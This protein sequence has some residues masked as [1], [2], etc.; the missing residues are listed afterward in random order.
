MANCNLCGASLYDPLNLE[1]VT[2]TTC[3]CTTPLIS[4][5][6]ANTG[7]CVESVTING[8]LQTGAVNFTITPYSTATALAAISAV[9]PILYNSGTGVISHY[10]SLVTGSP[11]TYG[12]ATFVPQ[13]TVDDKGHITAVSQVA[14]TTTALTTNLTNLD[15]GTT[16]SGTGYLVRTGTNTWVLRSLTTASSSRITITN[17]A[18]TAAATIFDLAS[19]VV[20]TGSG[21]YGSL[22]TYPIITVDTYGRVTGITTQTFP[23]AVIP[24]HSHHLGELSNVDST[25]G[26]AGVTSTATTGQVLTWSGTEWI[27]D[28]V[29]AVNAYVNST[30]TVVG[31][32]HKAKCVNT[33]DSI[34][35]G[36]VIDT[37]SK[38]T[39]SDGVTWVTVTAVLYILDADL[40]G[41]T[42]L[43]VE[44]AAVPTGYEPI[45]D[46]MVPVANYFNPACYANDALTPVAFTGTM[47]YDKGISIRFTPNGKVRL[48][49]DKTGMDFAVISAADYIVVPVNATYVTKEIDG[50]S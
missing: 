11:G 14:V 1:S 41:D 25:A 18:G 15:S 28:D 8:V 9:S 12:S 38:L 26:T 13:L 34:E 10:N 45:D 6:D 36:S 30:L 17:P 47:Y 49:Y 42:G 31:D 44:I 19:G 16:G 4:Q 23:V 37:I 43:D 2:S 24:P 21:T 20:T 5:A 33:V 50:G 35:T 3:N 48:N 46:V 27:P 7:C 39:D 29:P 32:W 40:A 22:T